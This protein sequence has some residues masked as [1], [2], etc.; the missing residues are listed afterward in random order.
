MT[1]VVKETETHPRLVSR[2]PARFYFGNKFIMAELLVHSNIHP[3]LKPSEAATFIQ[4]YDPKTGLIWGTA[5][6]VKDLNNNASQTANI[7]GNPYPFTEMLW[8]L[9]ESPRDVLYLEKELRACQLVT[10]VSCVCEQSC[11]SKTQPD[12]FYYEYDGPSWK[13]SPGFLSKGEPYRRDMSL[14]LCR[15]PDYRFPEQAFENYLAL[16]LEERI[17]QFI[18]ALSKYS[19]DHLK[20]S[21][22]GTLTTQK[23]YTQLKCDI[24]QLRRQTEIK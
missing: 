18:E 21:L 16:P 22:R 17:R 1:E 14:S 2:A 15:R 12:W 23:D 3:R 4:L 13:K 11:G 5:Q 6:D 8:L 20:L 7:L 10:E 19:Q 24:L 9:P